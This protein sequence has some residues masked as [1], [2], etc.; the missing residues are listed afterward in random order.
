[1]SGEITSGFHLTDDHQVIVMKTDLET[2]SLMMVSKKWITEDLERGRLRIAYYFHRV[3]E[4]KIFGSNFM[5]WSVYTA[6]LAP[7]TSIFLFCFLKL[8]DYSLLESLLF[9]FAAMV[10]PQTAI[11]WRLGPAETLGIFFLSASLFFLAL[12][13]ISINNRILFGAVF[14]I[15][16][17]LSAL[18]KESFLIFFPAIIVILIHF[19]RTKNELTWAESIKKNRLSIIVLMII[20]ITLLYYVKFVLGTIGTGYAGVDGFD[21]NTYRTAF[22]ELWSDDPFGQIVLLQM[23]VLA[24]FSLRKYMRNK[25]VPSLTDVV[26]PVIIFLIILIP[27][28][29]L[30]AKSGFFERYLLP[31]T[32]SYAIVFVYLLKNI[33]KNSLVAGGIIAVISVY[34]IFG[35]VESSFKNA[36]IFAQDGS[37]TGKLFTSIKMDTSRDA[38]FLIVGDPAMHYEWAD[39][40]HNIRHSF[41]RAGLATESIWNQCIVSFASFLHVASL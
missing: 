27:Q 34:A 31:A 7:M 13:V 21:F 4:A 8:L 30:Y 9:P 23:A 15:L 1:L 20:F 37:E 16:A 17:T 35:G 29:I 36:I 38:L 28:I 40:F 12:H 14:I 26:F 41:F 6:L 33:S 39:S 25:I 3:L 24:Y 18:T 5:L 10:G 19:S 2:Q 22:R 32:L 11:W